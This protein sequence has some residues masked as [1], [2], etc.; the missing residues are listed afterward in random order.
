MGRRND[1]NNY[2]FSAIVGQNLLKKA[3]ILNAIDPEIGGVLIRGERGTAKSTAVRSLAT[4]LPTQNVIMGCPYNCDPDRPDTMCLSCRNNTDRIS[5]ST[6]MKVIE[7]PVSATEDKVVG[8]LDISAAIKSGD[9]KFEPGILAEANRNI[10]Y[11]DEVNLLND[12]IIDI[13]L[14]SAAMGLNTVEREGISFSHPAK[15]ILIGTM[16]P[17]EGDLRPQLLDRFGLC[18]NIEAIDDAEDRMTIIQRIMDHSSD[19][20][21][22]MDKWR[23]KDEIISDRISKAKTTLHDTKISDPMLRSIIDICIVANVEGHRGDIAM[24]KTSKAIA[25]YDGRKEVEE[26]DVKLAAVLVLAHRAKDPPQYSSPD[27]DP[28]LDDEQGDEDEKNQEKTPHSQEH[29]EKDSDHHHEDDPNPGSSDSSTTRQFDTGEE[30]SIRPNSLKNENR[31]DNIIRESDGRRTDTESTNGRYIGYQMPHGKPKSIALDATIRAAAIHQNEKKVGLALNID[32]Q[33]IREKVKESKIGNLIVFVVDAS[34]SMGAQQRMMAVKGAISS[35]LT[36]AYQKRDTVSLVVFRGNAAEVVL[37]P[38]NSIVLAKKTMDKMPTGGKTPLGDGLI[39]AHELIVKEM[40][41]N[42]KIR[43]MM[44]L[45]SDGRGNVSI[46][47]SKP[48]EEIEKICVVIKESRYPVLVLDSE[49]GMLTLGFA[50]RL[51]DKMNAN[52][53]KLDDLRTETISTAVN[54]FS[55][56]I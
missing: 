26:R 20:I 38:T 1:S 16:N 21:G 36:D 7:L 45:L 24:L 27:D 56:S 34:G 14:D 31:A 33:D 25:A 35:I 42:A 48:M 32:E 8:T 40:S 30:Y 23:K 5:Y 11:V 52:Y 54:M 49:T 18:V 2:P 15:F 4:L 44:V 43:P 41:K 55:S 37:P 28:D 46:S 13:L 51:A 47:G 17:E 6:K 53:L 22:F 19:P 39:K 12:H 50:K 29:E 9:K 10:L 3:L